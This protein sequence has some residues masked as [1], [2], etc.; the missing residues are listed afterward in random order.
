MSHL[1]ES[2]SPKLT[3]IIDLNDHVLYEVFR[4]LTRIDLAA[5]ADVCSKFKWN[6][7]AV[8]PLLHNNRRFVA[9][10]I[11][12]PDHSRSILRNF[13]PVMNS[14]EVILFNGRERKCSQRI[15]KMIVQD[16]GTALI[17]LRMR[18]ITF[19]SD[20]VSILKP[21][22]NRKCGRCVRSLFIINF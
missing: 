20:L 6:A 19:T 2:V 13:G 17:D 7:Q 4:N 3:T 15:M 5:V 8:F 10:E 18:N 9:Y 21:L 1:T 14:L 22:L 12:D 16:C 11:N